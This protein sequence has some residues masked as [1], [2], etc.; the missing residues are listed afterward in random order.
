MATIL[1]IDDQ[2]NSRQPVIALLERHGHRALAASDGEEA[3][4]IVRANKPDLILAGV[5]MPD[6]NGCQFLM[7]MRAEAD[8]PQVPVVFRASAHVETEVRELARDCGVSQFVAKSAEPEVLLATIRSALAAPPPQPV[9]P[10]SGLGTAGVRLHS[11]AF[12]LQQRIAELEGFSA[13]LDRRM[14]EYA[15]QLMAARSA[16]E[17]EVTKRIW[18]EKE[19]TEANLRLHEK[20][21]RDGL[22]GL[23]NRGYLE[24]SLDREVSR[25]K[26]SGLPVG[27]MMIDIDHF[28]RCNDTFGH[29]AGDVVLRAVG[30]HVLSLTR[31]E[32]ILCRYG[33]EEFVL[34]MTHA[35]PRAV[36]GRAE[37]MRQGV[38]GLKVEYEGREV[39]PITLSIGVAMLPDHGESGNAV[40]QAADAALYQAK[41]EGRN[42][43]VVGDKVQA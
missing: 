24:E 8:M 36:W 39:G 23:Y 37:M 16:L 32:D 4:G 6:M 35:S 25:A 12:R 43:V 22:T 27:V 28:K 30:Q 40:L 17:Q 38:Q 20:A 2:K 42:C 21:V 33:G 7:R 9:T 11:L 29:A 41:R 3:L 34:V 15:A 31:G 1:I 18:A 14:S 19:L 26:R 10:Q 5:L 13:E